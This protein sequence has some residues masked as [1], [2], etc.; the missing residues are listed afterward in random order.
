MTVGQ[1]RAME[2]AV[3]FTVRHV[4]NV[5][6]PARLVSPDPTTD[7]DI[8]KSNWSPAFR[9]TDRV[10]G[11]SYSTQGAELRMVSAEPKLGIN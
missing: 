3:S 9:E 7:L 6:L 11:T 1:M 10:P 5:A 8:D 2:V 4:Q